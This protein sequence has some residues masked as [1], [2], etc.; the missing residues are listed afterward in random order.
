MIKLQDHL[1]GGGGGVTPTEVQTMI[2]NSLS[3]Y[4]E[5]LTAGTNVQI[6]NNVI[7]ATDT[8]YT[9]GDGISISNQNVISTVTKFWCGTELE[10]NQITTKD[11][12]TVY[13]IHE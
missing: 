10:Y 6:N 11:P 7:S 8:K 3:G 12:N 1:G 4:Q 2:D 9:A 13:M 5:E